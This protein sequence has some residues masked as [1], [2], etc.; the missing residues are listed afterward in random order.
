ML[1]RIARWSPAAIADAFERDSRELDASALARVLE[2]EPLDAIDLDALSPD[3]DEARVRRV[4][5]RTGF[6]L[7]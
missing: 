7:R 6:T 3:R 5:A 4:A 2:R 1:G